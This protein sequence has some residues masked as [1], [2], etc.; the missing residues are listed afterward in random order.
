MQLARM[1][2]VAGCR[3][4]FRN[5]KELRRFRTSLHR[6]RFNH[7]LRHSPEK[8]DYI[9]NPKTQDIA[10]FTMS[11]SMMSTQN[12]AKILKVFM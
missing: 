9:E 4:I 12:L 11:T 8:Y 1:D 2:D 3:L 7:K 5:E 6:A 10:A